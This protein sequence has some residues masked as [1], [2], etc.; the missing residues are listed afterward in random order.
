MAIQAA[1]E[2]T[3][4]LRNPAPAAPFARLGHQQNEALAKLT[5]IF[6]EIAAPEPIDEIT[7]TTTKSVQPPIPLITHTEVPFS[8]PS[9]LQHPRFTPPRVDG[10]TPR[11]EAPSPRVNRTA[12]KMM[13][14]MTNAHRTLNSGIKM[15]TASPH[16]DLYK[17]RIQS[18]QSPPRNAH[19][20]V[21]EWV[22]TY[23][24]DT[25]RQ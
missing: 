7:M 18:T 1:L 12:V 19:S 10:A 14:P 21:P 23:M 25:T 13:T 9:L 15:P 5:N 20:T 4:A 16:F 3:F 6:K 22:V 11:A 2:L 8:I 17:Q 24:G